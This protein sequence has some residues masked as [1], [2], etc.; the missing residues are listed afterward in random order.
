MS[1]ES[2]LV[3]AP[4]PLDEILG[5]GGAIA[6]HSATGARVS[7]LYLTGGESERHK[8][9]KR[10]ARD[11]SELL[12]AEPPQFADLPENRTDELPLCEL[13]G[14]IEAAVRATMPERVY[15]SHGGN[16]N[17]D[18]QRAFAATVTACRPM[19]GASVREILAY[20]VLSSTDWAPAVSGMAPF[21]PNVLVDI[22]ATIDRKMQA[23][24]LYGEEMR[25]A[26]HAR[27]S[28]S[29]RAL[30][31]IR[32]HSVGLNAAEAFALIRRIESAR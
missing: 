32:G 30:A 10:A 28:E 25:S 11:C 20:E 14:I 5:A 8:A 23:L 1:N 24:D 18:H 15:V 16:L 21:L 12:G 19:P 22:S 29:V 31:R 9:L 13:I 7:V 26:P 3:I 27:S 6:A 17:L 2:I 4:H